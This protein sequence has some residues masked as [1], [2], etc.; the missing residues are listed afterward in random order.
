MKAKTKKVKKPKPRT[1]YTLSPEDKILYKQM[2]KSVKD[3]LKKGV[4]CGVFVG[5]ASMLA[6][7]DEDPDNDE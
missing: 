3:A 6:P 2:C 7:K 1:K 4:P 5:T